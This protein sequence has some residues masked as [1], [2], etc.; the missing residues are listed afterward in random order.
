M[1]PPSPIFWS[2]LLYLPVGV[3][4]VTVPRAWPRSYSTSLG[5]RTVPVSRGL[6][7][8]TQILQGRAI[9]T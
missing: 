3:G 2:I 5:N 7:K 4:F 8:G 9:A 1:Q 6:G